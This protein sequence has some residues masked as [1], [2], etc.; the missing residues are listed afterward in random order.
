MWPLAGD[1]SSSSCRCAAWVSSW[2]GSWFSSQHVTQKR[3]R[4]KPHVF[5]KVG[6]Q[7]TFCHYTGWP[8]FW[9]E[10]LYE[11]ENIRWQEPLGHLGGWL[12]QRSTGSIRWFKE[13]F[14]EEVMPK[15]AKSGTIV[16]NL[17]SLDR[18]QGVCKLESGEIGLHLHFHIAILK[19]NILSII[20]I[21]N[22]WQCCW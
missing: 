17:G 4:Q 18:T 6:L 21:R 20:N 3:T 13:D 19:F 14:L 16:Y 7:V 12:P 2:H 8:Y 22:P 11:R 9:W 1:L 5:C 10:G 15:T